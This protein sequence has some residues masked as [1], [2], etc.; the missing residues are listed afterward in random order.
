MPNLPESL[1]VEPTVAGP[2]PSASPMPMG[3]NS[4]SVNQLILL[5]HEP[6]H[7]EDALYFL[8]K[9]IGTTNDLALSLW[10]SFNTVYI[11]LQ[12]VIS[13]YKLLTPTKLTTTNSAH[14]CNALALLQCVAA[15]PETKKPFINAKIPVYLYPFLKT[16]DNEK[17]FEFLRLS[18]LAVIGALVKVDDDP[19]VVHFLLETEIFP[20]CLRCMDL[21]NVL[22]KKVATFIV[23][24]IL[25]QEEGLRYCCDFVERFFAV[26]RVLG[27]MVE[28]LAEKPTLRLLKDIISCYLTLSEVPRACET[29]IH[30]LP[31][32][33]KDATFINIFN[34]D[35]VATRYLQQLLYNVT[36]GQWSRLD[37]VGDAFGRLR[38]S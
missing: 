8:N 1:F 28:K 4:A 36:N 10:N 6:Q 30:F 19:Q 9:R 18:S 15:H 24:K 34:E 23:S 7:R 2:G 29:L 16:T 37:E 17:P 21:G 32:R 22:S 33:L 38:I 27:G 12:E 26:V 31:P 20:L 5:L 13:C 35:P 11:L 3:L 14:V 25:M